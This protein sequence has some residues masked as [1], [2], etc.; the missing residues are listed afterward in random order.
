MLARLIA[1]IAV[2][3]AALAPPP[4]ARHNTALRA[5]RW[6]PASSGAGEVGGGEP[7]KKA[8]WTRPAPVEAFDAAAELAR[9]ARAVTDG[10]V[11]ADRRS[12]IVSLPRG[13]TGVEWGTD[14]SF[15]GVYVRALLPGGAAEA[16][17]KVEAGDQ[18]VAV[19]GV[20]V[21][22]ASF[23]GAMDA[24]GRCSEPALDVEVFRGSRA[25]LLAALGQSVAA[26]AATHVVTVDDD[27]RVLALEV[28]RGACL[29][30]ALVDA[31]VDVYRGT[32]AWTNCAGHQMCGTCVVDVTRGGEG[33]N[34]KSNDE[35]GTLDIQGCAPSCRLACVTHVYGD[36]DVKLR[37]DREGGFFGSATSG[38]GW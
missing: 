38:S 25:E 36:I 8:R 28:P 2:G 9:E 17:G 23:D 24:L 35:G 37:P 32:T 4:R 12:S 34:Y 3:V 15:V 29:R 26:E 33:T 22:D 6:D 13:A 7:K 21:Y 30:D 27:G 18:L 20:G 11:V 10:A 16:S 1:L 19:G 31:G 5:K 14:L